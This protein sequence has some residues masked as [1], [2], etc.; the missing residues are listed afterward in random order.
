MME[1]GNYTIM[2]VTRILGDYN[3]N[4]NDLFFPFFI[5]IMYFVIFTLTLVYSFKIAFIVSSLF[6]ASISTLFFAM[7][8]ISGA[9][10]F[11]I[12]ATFILAVLNMFF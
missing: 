2:N 9:F 3:T 4:T 11:M 8:L 10:L 12:W 6:M 5:I 1:F 7:G